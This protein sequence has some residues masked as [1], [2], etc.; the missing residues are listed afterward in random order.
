MPYLPLTPF[1]AARLGHKETLAVGTGAAVLIPG[2]IQ[3]VS[4]GLA[5]QASSSGRVEFTLSPVAEVQAG[6]ALWHSWPHS[7]VAVTTA[8]VLTA[9][10]TAVRAVVVSGTCDFEVIGA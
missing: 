2:G 7:D 3:Q 1:G 6:T 10:V 5:P 8:D 4:I 9:P